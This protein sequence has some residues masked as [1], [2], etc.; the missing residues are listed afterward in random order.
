[1]LCDY[2][3]GQEA[4]YQ[5]KNGKWCCNK[6]KNSCEIFRKLIG[7]LLRK[8][9]RDNPGLCDYGCG[10]EAKFYLL[11]VNKWCCSKSQNGC[12]TIRKKVG[13]GNKGKTTSDITKK[14]LSKSLKGISFEQHHG[15]EKSIILKRQISERMKSEVGKHVRSCPKDSL[16]LQIKAEKQKQ[17]MLNGGS[18]YIR[19]F[20]KS[21]S[22]P[23]LKLREVVAKIYPNYKYSYDILNYEVDIALPEYM[24]I[25]EYDG[26]Y[27]HQ[28]VKYDLERQ[29][30]IEKVGWKFIRFIDYIPSIEELKMKIEK[31]IR[32]GEK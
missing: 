32:K 29:I 30:K 26:S 19:K 18:Q 15:K 31:N 10:K 7:N 20:I 5:F 27:F 9:R 3:C 1:M 16:K 23:E 11:T 13:D 14:K 28:N 12:F 21:P 25:I 8:P 17:K 6:S 24:I 2:G 22:K 4:M